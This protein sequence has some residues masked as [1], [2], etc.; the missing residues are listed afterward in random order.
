MTL[1]VRLHPLVEVDLIEA[2]RWYDGQ[3]AGLGDR[4][5]STVEAAIQRATRWPNTGTPV[6]VGDGGEIIER[7]VAPDDFPFVIRYRVT[8]DVLIVMAVH[9][10]HRRPDFGSDRVP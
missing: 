7:K 5:L 4:F 9:H 6:L 10:Q 3:S 1:V 2:W 8:T